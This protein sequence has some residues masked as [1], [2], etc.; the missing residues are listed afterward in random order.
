M[1]YVSSRATDRFQMPDAT[2]TTK[3]W[4]INDVYTPQE[5][6]VKTYN[7]ET[8]QGLYFFCS[9]ATYNYF[10]AFDPAKT[11]KRISAY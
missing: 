11:L 1:G 2:S 9:A 4:C 6:N 5:I 10:V 7:D 8:G 3:V